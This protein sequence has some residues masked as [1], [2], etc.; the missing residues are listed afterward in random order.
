MNDAQA[1]RLGRLIAQARRNKS[2]SLRGLS[3]LT[4]IP[5]LWLSRVEHGNF[6]QPAP[7]RLTQLAEALGID[8]ERIDRVTKGHVSNSLPGVRTYFRAKYDLTA[9]EIDEIERSVQDIQRKHE[10]RTNRDERSDKT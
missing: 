4:G 7:E 2:I 9:D 5:H 10:R 8:P 1:M 3:R 6:N